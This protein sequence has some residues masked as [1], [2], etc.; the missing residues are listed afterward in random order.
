MEIDNEKKW[1][2]YAAVFNT[3]AGKIVLQD[4]Q[5]RAT[6]LSGS[7]SVSNDV[8]RCAHGQQLQLRYIKSCIKSGERK[9][10]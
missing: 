7:E 6:A 1:K 8:L 3:A 2:I 5:E 10:E 4:L 9:Y